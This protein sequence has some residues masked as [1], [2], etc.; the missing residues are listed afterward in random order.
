MKRIFYQVYVRNSAYAIETYIRAFNA[1]ILNQAISKEGINIHTELNFYG[2]V[3][4]ISELSSSEDIICT[5]NI[6]QICLQFDKTEKD[7]LL[8]AYNVLKVNAT[9]IQYPLSGCFYSE[10][11]AD[12]TDQFGV[13]WCLF[14]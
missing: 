2:N 12:V 14:V 11:M 5:G 13:R 1:V 3:L 8:N 6:M 7:M 9:R 4:A 10:Y